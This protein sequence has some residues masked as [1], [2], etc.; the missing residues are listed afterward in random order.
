MNELMEGINILN[1]TTEISNVNDVIM[2]LL[3]CGF[4][5]LVGLIIFICGISSSDIE[6]ISVGIVVII[7]FGFGTG[8]LWSWYVNF[9]YKEYQVYQVTLSDNIKYKEFTEKYDVIKQEGKIYII[10]LKENK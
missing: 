3:V 5:A 4:L 6:F 2:P 8:I 1:Q 10:K 7:L 9:T